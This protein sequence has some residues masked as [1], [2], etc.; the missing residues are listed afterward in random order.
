MGLWKAWKPTLFGSWDRTAAT[1]SIFLNPLAIFLTVLSWGFLW[2]APTL[3]II[4]DIIIF[5][6]LLCVILLLLSRYIRS[7]RYRIRLEDKLKSPLAQFKYI[8]SMVHKLRNQ[9]FASFRPILPIKLEDRVKE[10]DKYIFKKVCHFVTT[11][12]R[13]MLLEYFKFK[14]IDLRN[15]LAITIKLIVPTS[16]ISKLLRG[17]YA[18]NTIQRKDSWIITAYRDPYTYEEHPNREVAKK[19]YDIEYNTAFS[20]ILIHQNPHF[21]CNDLKGLGPVYLNE[22]HDWQKYYNSTMVVPIRYLDDRY[23]DIMNKKF[24]IH[25]G[26]IAVDSLNPNGYEIFDD[27]GCKELISYS[28]DLLA[29]FFLMMEM[30]KSQREE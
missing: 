21:W 11:E 19:L 17:T 22:T 30:S 7:E 5:F 13:L 27:Q 25:Y 16:T 9:S 26:L 2:P 23:L 6:G 10:F 18:E 24:C 3:L 14:N 20:Y 4:R 15:D 12:L 28:A 1:L 29:L 8:H